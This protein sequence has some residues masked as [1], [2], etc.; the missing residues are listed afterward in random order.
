MKTI[1]WKPLLI[2]LLIPLATGGLSGLLT[3]DHVAAF[4]SMNQPPL[5][6]PAFLF[7]IVWTILFSLMGISAY[8]VYTSDSNTGNRKALTLYGMQLA[9][10]FIWPLIFFNVQNYL[11]AFIWI[12]L[13]WVLI[14]AMLISFYKINHTAAF[15][16]I[17]YL[18]WVTFA[19]YLNCGVWILNR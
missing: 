18:L 9:A 6:P 3:K 8:L 11:L 17:P 7:P 19:A 2:S 1:Q 4:Q 16:Q 14:L 12:L 10:N 15:L 5:S 13:L